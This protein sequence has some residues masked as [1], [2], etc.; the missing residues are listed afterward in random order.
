MM[1]EGLIILLP[2]NKDLGP[3][4]YRLPDV[5]EVVPLRFGMLS[6]EY[7]KIVGGLVNLTL[8]DRKALVRENAKQ[9]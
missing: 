4:L 3:Q 1:P 6:D 5:G 8:E 9:M 2:L 7:L